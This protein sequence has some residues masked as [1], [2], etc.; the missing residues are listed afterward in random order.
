M[1][2]FPRKTVSASIFAL[3][4]VASVF[5]WL[6]TANLYLLSVDS[7][8]TGVAGDQIQ[9]QLQKLQSLMIASSILVTIVTIMYVHFEH[10]YRNV[11]LIMNEYISSI[12]PLLW[13]LTAMAVTVW[14][15]ASVPSEDVID[16]N[17]RSDRLLT[18]SVVGTVALFLFTTYYLFEVR[19]HSSRGE[20]RLKK[21]SRSKKRT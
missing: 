13:G 19:R 4:I 2:E 21:E 18:C 9:K 10:S 15:S 16:G 8:I 7:S 17:T 11:H 6:F 3:L 14:W 5:S 1:M 12:F 20:K